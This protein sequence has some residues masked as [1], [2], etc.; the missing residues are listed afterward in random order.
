MYYLCHYVDFVAY[1]ILT[2]LKLHIIIPE[3][4][5]VLV[6]GFHRS[7]LKLMDSFN[8]QW[9]VVFQKPVTDMNQA[10]LITY[11]LVQ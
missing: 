6:F 3:T 7:S 10:A 8:L 4:Y 2:H 5:T 11:A 1:F 9:C